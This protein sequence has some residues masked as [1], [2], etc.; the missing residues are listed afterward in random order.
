MEQFER[1]DAFWRNFSVRRQR[2]S[3]KPH[4]IWH[5]FAAGSVRWSALTGLNFGSFASHRFDLSHWHVGDGLGR[6][7]SAELTR[8]LE[9]RERSE[10]RLAQGVIARAS[11]AVD[12]ELDVRLHEIIA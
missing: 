2:I 10:G 4:V 8:R 5:V 9:C 1:V 3:D 11:K 6:G 12:R 7:S